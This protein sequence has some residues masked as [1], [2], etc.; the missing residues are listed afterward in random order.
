MGVIVIKAKHWYKG[1]DK[2]LSGYIKDTYGTMC[3]SQ[4]DA[5][6]FNSVSEANEFIIRWLKPAYYKDLEKVEYKL[7]SI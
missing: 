4:I 5:R 2:T 7:V 1:V 6:K 3:Q